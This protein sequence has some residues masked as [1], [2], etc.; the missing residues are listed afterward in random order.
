MARDVVRVRRSPTK[1]TT[2]SDASVRLARYLRRNKLT[3]AVFADTLG[4]APISVSE[5]LRGKVPR[6]VTAIAIRELT[7]IP[8]DSWVRPPKGP[9]P[10]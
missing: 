9:M 8:L 3:H 7:R 5:W 6:L 2:F 4:V 10:R 1:N